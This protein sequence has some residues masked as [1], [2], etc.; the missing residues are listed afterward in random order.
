MLPATRILLAVYVFV[1][2]WAYSLDLGAP[3]GNIARVTGLLALAAVILRF[4]EA[5]SLPGSGAIPLLTLSFFLLT[6]ISYFWSVDAESSAATIRGSFQKI[7]VVWMIWAVCERQRDLRMLLRATVAGMMMLAALTAFTLRSAQALLETEMRHAANG[8]DPNDV[9]HFLAL[10]LPL[11]ALLAVSEKT[12]LARWLAAA[13][14][15]C[16]AMAILLTASRGGLIAATLALCFCLAMLMRSARRQ[17]MA[18][19]ALMLLAATVGWKA[20][21]AGNLERLATIPEQLH[22]GD[23]NQRQQIWA[24]GWEAFQAAPWLGSGAGGFTH[25]AHT[26]FNDTAHNTAMAIS[27]NTGLA[28]LSIVLAIALCAM[29]SV[30]RLRA[31]EKIALAGSLLTCGVSSLVSTVEESRPAWLLLAL[32]VLA[33]QKSGEAL[34]AEAQ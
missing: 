28:G 10:G 34:P 1:L 25:A 22:G 16:T 12:R 9:A 30:M 14:I 15:P 5:R 26:A 6:C 29:R 3:W 33:T 23:F 18:A 11:A 20:V 4:L 19:L 17:T 32:I 8:Q 13:T 21:H 31:P 7:M 24:S 2:P 27:V